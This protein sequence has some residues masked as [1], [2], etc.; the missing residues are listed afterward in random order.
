MSYL[1]CHTPDCKWSQDDFWDWKFTFKFW[2]WKSRPFGYNPLSLIIEDISEYSYPRF[3]SDGK[4]KEFSWFIMLSQI[5][6]HAKRIF[7][8]K[9]WTYNSFKKDVD[10]KCPRC[11]KIDFDID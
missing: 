5:K 11:G 7:T 4:N 3:I 6:R 9:W 8:Q 10:A 2:K 1:H